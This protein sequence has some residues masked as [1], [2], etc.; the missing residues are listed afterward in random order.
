VIQVLPQSEMWINPE[1]GFAMMN[2]YGNLKNRVGIQVGQI[3]GVII[4]K[5]TE[6]GETGKPKPRIRNGTKTTDSW[7]SFV[8]TVIPYQTRQEDNSFDGKTP[9][10]TK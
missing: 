2:K 5:A 3:K 7:V 4:E 1:V 10:S 9:I 6:K 8:G